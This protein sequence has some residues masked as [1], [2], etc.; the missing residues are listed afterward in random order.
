[1]IVLELLGTGFRVLYPRTLRLA[2]F[3]RSELLS[4]EP[5][6]P[7][8]SPGLVMPEP[9]RETGSRAR[10]LSDVSAPLPS[11]VPPYLPLGARQRDHAWARCA[12]VLELR[13]PC[14]GA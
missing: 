12:P 9:P 4:R 6:E 3:L 13:R 10:Q 14:R 8:E 1:M 7:A 2:G 5:P 11:P